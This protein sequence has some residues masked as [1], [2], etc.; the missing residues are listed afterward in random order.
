MSRNRPSHVPKAKRRYGF[1]VMPVL[2]GD[3]LVGRIDPVFD[4]ATGRLVVNAVYPEPGRTLRLE[5]PLASLAGFV[6]ATEVA[7]PRSA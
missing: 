7:M 2:D 3:E 6:G 5:E 4:R 1:F